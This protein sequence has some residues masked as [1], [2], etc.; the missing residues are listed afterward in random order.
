MSSAIVIQED[1]F[2][3]FK[4]HNYVYSDRYADDVY[5]YR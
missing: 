2:A 1:L 4:H 5:E 3:S